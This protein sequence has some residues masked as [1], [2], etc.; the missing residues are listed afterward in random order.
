MVK[1]I[2]R[3]AFEIVPYILKSTT[4]SSIGS[5]TPLKL[6]KLLYYVQAWSL[7]FRGEA[8]FC[9]DIEAWIHGPVVT[10]IYRHYK[11]YSYNPLPEE[12]SIN[13]LKTEEVEVLNIVLM[14]YRKKSER[15]LEELTHSEY[16]WLKAREGFRANQLSDRKI[17]IRDMTTYY[18][19]FIESDKPRKISPIALK[20]KEFQRKSF[21]SNLLAGIGSSLDIIPTS[22]KHSFY[23]SDDFSNSDSDLEAMFSDWEKVGGDL[24]TAI[25]LV[26]KRSLSEHE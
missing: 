11:Q 6:Q 15:F 8:L 18:T 17:S 14:N 4:R 23:A 20:K 13:E 3:S 25:N 19:Q 10:S 21:M 12:S 16:P 5:V 22:S 26:E 1:T 24:Q 7:V 9:E 2:M